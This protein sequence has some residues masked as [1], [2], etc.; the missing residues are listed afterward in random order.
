MEV[1]EKLDEKISEGLDELDPND[2]KYS[3]KVEAVR[4]LY[5]LKI[6]EMK[7]QNDYYCRATEL[8]NKATEL[9]QQKKEAEKKESWLEKINPNTVIT[10]VAMGIGTIVTLNFEKDGYLFRPS[11]FVRKL[12]SN[13]K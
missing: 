3:E 6:Q 10:T 9:E 1:Y 8:D 5:D 4:D 11:E 13:N 2:P 7:A 12:I